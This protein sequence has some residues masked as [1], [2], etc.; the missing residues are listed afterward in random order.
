MEMAISTLFLI[1]LSQLNDFNYSWVNGSVKDF[2]YTL[3]KNGSVG[4]NSHGVSEWEPDRLASGL[5]IASLQNTSAGLAR[6]YWK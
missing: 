6:A 3:T 2:A 5:N 4:E 1:A